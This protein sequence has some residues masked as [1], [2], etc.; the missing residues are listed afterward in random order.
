M[1]PE[2]GSSQVKKWGFTNQ[3][4]QP[5][6]AFGI[7][8]VTGSKTLS[9]ILWFLGEETQLLLGMTICRNR[10][11]GPVS[12]LLYISHLLVGQRSAKDS[13]L[14]KKIWACQ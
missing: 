13:F 14:N 4:P 3:H 10:R 9:I 2:P 1:P 6:E 12:G 5:K 8:M 11:N 7:A